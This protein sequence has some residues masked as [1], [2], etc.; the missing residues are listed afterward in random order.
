MTPREKTYFLDRLIEEGLNNPLYAS[1]ADL[2]YWCPIRN[3]EHDTD[4]KTAFRVNLDKLIWYCFK[5]GKGGTAFQLAEAKLGSKAAARTMFGVVK[6]RM[7]NG[8]TKLK[9]GRRERLI[10]QRNEAKAAPPRIETGD[11]AI[12]L[13]L[14]ALVKYNQLKDESAFYGVQ[15]HPVHWAGREWLGFR[16]LT[17]SWKLVGLDWDGRIRREAG[18]I[19]KRNYGSVS[20]V[21][22]DKLRSALDQGHAIPTLYDVEG[23]GDLL[24]AIEHGLDPVLTSTGGAGSTKGHELCRT[25]L[26]KLDIGEVQIVRDND[27]TGCHGAKITTQFWDSLEVPN[28]VVEL[29]PEVGD[30]GDLRD[31]FALLEGGDSRHERGTA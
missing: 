1:G 26:A 8:S 15:Q 19:Q 20:L 27:D 11:V 14:D 4:R 22:S 2:H 24:C 29:P 3:H 10:E 6:R 18:A 5:C 23:E 17:D 9:F 13:N 28:K 7:G 25:L 31:Y 21:A 30:G 16:T 12:F